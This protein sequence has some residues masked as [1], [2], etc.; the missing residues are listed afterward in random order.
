ML[1][2]LT[3]ANKTEEMI[4]FVITLADSNKQFGIPNKDIEK[5]L[6]DLKFE[7]TITTEK[8]K[9][10][11]YILLGFLKLFKDDY[12]GALNS[13]GLSKPT[14]A[15][16][17]MEDLAQIGLSRTYLARNDKN[18]IEKA[19]SIWIEEFFK[20]KDEKKSSPYYPDAV[21]LFK[22]N[23]YNYA[24][25]FFDKKEYENAIKYYNLVDEYLE[26]TIEE[27]EARYFKAVAQFNIQQFEKSLESFDKVLSNKDITRD[28]YAIF[29]I[30]KVNATMGDLSTDKL[31]KMAKFEIALVI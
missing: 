6:D 7:T 27:E 12:Q 17:P 24:K 25:K 16:K 26:D 8:A 23:T 9:R 5:R 10:H 20:K 2:F 1:N 31:E 4:D 30:G 14:D 29:Y 21:N 28:S 22:T 3:D 13:F 15:S 18:D 11:I 19:I